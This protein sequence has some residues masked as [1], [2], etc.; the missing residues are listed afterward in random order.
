MIALCASLPYPRLEFPPRQALF[1]QEGQHRIG[2]RRPDLV[3]QLDRRPPDAAL[4]LEGRETDRRSTF[5]QPSSLDTHDLKCHPGDL[6]LNV[7][8]GEENLTIDR[9]RVADGKCHRDSVWSPVVR[10]VHALISS[11]TAE[12]VTKT[13]QRRAEASWLM[14]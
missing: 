4:V 9:P 13:P 5:W 3:R 10:S 11:S 12:R 8:Q 1:Q 2:Q 14:V 6:H 7:D